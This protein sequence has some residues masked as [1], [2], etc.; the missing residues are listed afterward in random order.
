VAG[1]ISHGFEDFTLFDPS[2]PSWPHVWLEYGGTVSSGT[3]YCCGVTASRSHPEPA[4]VEGIPIPLI[5]DE[6]FR[7]FDRLIQR[8]FDTVVHV[9]IVGR[10][11]SGRQE[12]SPTGVKM[13]GYG[14][15]GCCS[16]LAIQRVLS[17][18][19]QDRADVDYRTS[20][21]QLDIG[22]AG[23]G[24]RNLPIS[25]DAGLIG[26]QRQ[27]E[28]EHN[29][30]AFIDPQRVASDALARILKIDTTTIAGM[31]QKRKSQGRVLYEWKP[32]GKRTRYLVV[33]SRQYWLSFY[34]KDPR[35]IAWVIIAA[36]E[37]S[38]K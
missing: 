26:A 16:L 13:G 34:A 30:W 29:G 2:C 21:D 6:R 11:F 10:F 8:R 19:P 32:K 27:A 24:Y 20:A 9:T 33:A 3:I 28:L 7:E 37:Y 12:P 23:C 38:C 31:R 14:H 36:Y 17:V 1:F 18:E 4:I 15:M 5:D 25:S 22:K 35:R